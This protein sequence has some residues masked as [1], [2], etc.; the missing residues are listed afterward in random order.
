MY[1]SKI[2]LILLILSAFTVMPIVYAEDDEDDEEKNNTF[3]SKEGEDEREN[4]GEDE[5][6]EDDGG[7]QLGSG[8]NSVI[9]YGTIAAI[10]T[11]I[12]Y[13]GFKIFASRR[14]TPKSS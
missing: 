12:G 9:L 2:F 7:L 1:S 11:A 8:I 3:G 5:R 6:G 13:S 14:K 10:A 4:E